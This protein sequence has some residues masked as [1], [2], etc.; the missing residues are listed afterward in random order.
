MSTPLNDEQW[1]HIREQLRAGN[2]IEA[3][4]T[5]RDLTGTGLAEAKVAIDKLNSELEAAGEV[6]KRTGCLAVVLLFLAAA[7]VLSRL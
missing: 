4:K 2:K 6:P 3:I 7:G 1:Q 5:Y